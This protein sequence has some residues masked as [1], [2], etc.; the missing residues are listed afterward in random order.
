MATELL[1]NNGSDILVSTHEVLQACSLKI[2]AIKINNNQ[3]SIKYVIICKIII[4]EI[5]RNSIRQ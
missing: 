1:N 3:L 5:S 2:I 4:T